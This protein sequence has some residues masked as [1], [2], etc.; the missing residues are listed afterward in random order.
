MNAFTVFITIVRCVTQDTEVVQ[1]AMDLLPDAIP[2]QYLSTT[3]NILH[4]SALELPTDNEGRTRR[5]DDE[6]NKWIQ[7]AVTLADKRVH[8]RRRLQSK[9]GRRASMVILPLPAVALVAMAAGNV[10]AWTDFALPELRSQDH[11][12]TLTENEEVPRRS[13]RPQDRHLGRVGLPGLA[14]GAGGRGRLRAGAVRGQV[15][16]RPG[17]GARVRRGAHLHRRSRPEVSEGALG[18]L[19]PI[20]LLVG[21][22][23]SCVLSCFLDYRF[24]GIPSCVVAVMTLRTM[25]LIPETPPYFVKKRRIVDAMK[26]LQFFR[27]SRYDARRE[28]QDL[29]DSINGCLRDASAG[30]SSASKAFIVCFGM[31][32]FRQLCGYTSVMLLAFA[33]FH[34]SGVRVIGTNGFRIV[35]TLAQVLVHCTAGALLDRV[36]RRILLM[37]SASAMTLYSATVAYYLSFDEDSAE[38]TVAICLFGFMIAFCLGFGPVPWV[39]VGELFPQRQGRVRQRGGVHALGAGAAD[40]IL[41]GSRAQVAGAGA[42]V[43]PVRRCERLVGFLCVVF[44]SGD[45][46]EE[47]HRNPS[48]VQ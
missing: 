33:M 34:N 22:L 28:V 39:M 44:S 29:E 9:S 41:H 38:F 26:S 37:I 10:L 2:L 27:G 35:C 23:Y 21:K 24:L 7:C 45:K 32:L 4:G 17:G 31:I 5:T 1:N 20:M 25:F 13:V 36:G 16:G 48:A 47:P 46:E 14:L 19:L 15:R 3:P 6:G 30:W 40:V 12:A 18:M 43:P 42:L 8:E 11:G